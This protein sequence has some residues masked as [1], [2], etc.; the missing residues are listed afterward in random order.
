MWSSL[1]HPSVSILEL[2][3][4]VIMVYGFIL[5]LL[6][7]S[8]KRQLGQLSAIE[9]VS[10][11]L[12]SNAVQNAM[13]AGDNSLVGGLVLAAGLV[14]LSTV[15]SVLSYRNKFFRHLV[16]GTPTI[17][18]RHGKVIEPCLKRERVTREDLV[19]ML[20]RQGIHHI[21]DIELAIMESDGTLSVELATPKVVPVKS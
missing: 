3:I 10:I 21:P 7:I 20:R 6:R 11:L 4:R 18:I 15:T 17:L 9:F 2:L 12:I 1:T 13:N 14:A 16:E 19:V 8:G 5:F